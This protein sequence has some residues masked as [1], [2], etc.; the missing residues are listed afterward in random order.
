M[1]EQE[2]KTLTDEALIEKG[3]KAK[4]YAI[5]NA[6]MIGVFVGVAIFSTYK[7]GMGFFTVFPLFFVFILLKSGQEYKVIERELKER[8]PR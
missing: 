4:T 2:L 7:K 3:K 5:I 8:N 6:V 1:T